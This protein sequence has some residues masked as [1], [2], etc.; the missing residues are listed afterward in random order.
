[1]G[2]LQDKETFQWGLSRFL[3]EARILAKLN[4]PNVV[5]VKQFFQANGTAYLVMEYCVGKPLDEIIRDH[6]PLNNEELVPILDSLLDGVEHVHSND[7]LHRDI[8]PANIFIRENGSPVLLDFGAA[9]SE[10]TSHSRSVTSLATAGYAPFEQ[11]STK[12][13]QGPWSD[14][15]GLAA[16]LY[17]TITGIKPQDAPDRILED[18]VVQCEKLLDGK[19]NRNLLF[20]IDKAMS[21]RP[22]NRPQSISEFKKLIYSTSNSFDKQ[23]SKTN[24]VES[25]NFE[26]KNKTIKIFAGLILILAVA[27]IVNLIVRPLPPSSPTLPESK[28]ASVSKLSEPVLDS[29]KPNIDSNESSRA[30]STQITPALSS[31]PIEQVIK[32]KTVDEIALIEFQKAFKEGQLIDAEQIL[33]KAINISSNNPKLY[34]EMAQLLVNQKRYAEASVFITKAKTIDSSLSFVS[35]KDRFISVLDEITSFEKKNQYDDQKN[36]ELNTSIYAI[37]DEGEQCYARKKFDCAISSAN[38][39]LRLRSDNERAMLLKT[40]AQNAQKAAL[41]SISVN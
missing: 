6:G 17:R 37:L 28:T 7:F 15:Y 40:R 24:Y 41:D 8:K 29:K 21:V 11:Y 13:K 18:Q 32:P 16:T 1:V 9:K 38:N 39:V 5:A 14:V 20:A 2:N 4:H 23:K 27:G 36:L 33:K 30:S 31:K 10:M 34:F 25:G 19:F 35:N 22:E 3:E 26:P 12:G